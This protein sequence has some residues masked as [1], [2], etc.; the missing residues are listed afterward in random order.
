M[1]EQYFNTMGDISRARQLFINNHGLTPNTVIMNR[2]SYRN[3]ADHH[4]ML[5][6][7]GPDKSVTVMG[8]KIQITDVD[9]IQ[10]GYMIEVPDIE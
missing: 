6:N 7:M 4:E 3:L 1:R 5:T 9:N 10:V 2:T 8:M